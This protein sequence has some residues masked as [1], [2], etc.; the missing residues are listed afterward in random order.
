MK[1]TVITKAQLKAE[2]ETLKIPFSNLL[3]GYLLEELLYLITESEYS[4]CLWL[5][6]SGILGV[7]Q[8]K[9]KENGLR[10][11]F[12]Y[13]VRSGAEEKDG[14]Y[15]GQR[16]SLKLAYVMLLQFLEKGK[17]PKIKWKGK[18][19]LGENG[20]E[21][22]IV[23]EFEE[24]AVP[25]R[26]CMTEI[27]ADDNYMP[28]PREF[29]PFMAPEEEISYLEYPKEMLLAEQLGIILKQME[30]IQDMGAYLK[31]YQILSQH[32]FDGRHVKAL[33]L[34]I[35]EKEGISTEEKRLQELLSYRKYSYMRKRWEKYLRRLEQT[36]P[37]W[38]KM[39]DMLEK[40]LNPVWLAVSRD[41]IF[42]GDWM[43]D[44]ERFL[45]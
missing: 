45:D 33:L 40:F 16:I 21:Y 20:V 38:E 31:I 24:M 34:R 41:E 9:K 18:A 5:K 14:P 39:M 28:V 26:V 11:D 30:L 37:G 22:E 29:A 27:M 4:A 43:P 19:V 3:A 44:L 10:L 8:Y 2:S 1:H 32:S 7:E 36:E 42:F 25:L 12:A 13:I 23:G 15:P 6:N 17:T 35:C